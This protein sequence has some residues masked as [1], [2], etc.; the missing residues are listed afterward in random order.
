[1]K[2]LIKSLHSDF[3]GYLKDESRTVGHAET[4]SFPKS[5]DEICSILAEL[6]KTKTKITLQ[7]ARTGLAAGA[8]PFGGHV[9]NLGKMNRVLGLRH[10]N[11]LFYVSVQPGVILS[12]L[13]KDIEEKRFRMDGW[14]AESV[15]AAKKFADS[16]EHFFPTDP[17]ESSAC[18]GGIAACNA[19]GARSYLYKS[20]R[21]HISALRLA[22]WDGSMLSLQRGRTFARGR[23]LTIEK[24]DGTQLYVKLPGLT[25]PDA[26]NAS[27]Y[28]VRDDMDAID[29]I[30]G[31]DG[32]LGAITEIE[33]ELLPLPSVIWGVSTFFKS[34]MDAVSFVRKVRGELTNIAAIEYFDGGAIN[35]L[36]GQKASCSAFAQLPDIA[37]EADCCVYIEIHCDCEETALERL[38]GIGGRAAASG[39]DERDTWVARNSRD[40]ESLQFFRH[41]VPES[42]NMF[43]DERKKKD[44]IITK[45]GADM[46]VQRHLLPE[47]VGV[48]REGLAE[49]GLDSAVWGHIGDSHLHV[50][51]LPRDG[52]DFKKGKELFSKWAR[53]IS[54]MGGSVSAEHGV[55]KI[56]ANFLEFMYGREHVRGMAETK[57]CFD[58]HFIFGRGNLFPAGILSEEA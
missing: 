44:P 52:E 48:Y 25:M 29:L 6:A 8:V 27:G 24:E 23:E 50:N 47:V 58:P 28:Y 17:T 54:D 33:L 1:M 31:S 38:Y 46:S 49:Y 14:S 19:S 45:L 56:K 2:D 30:I 39:G 34:E 20:A 43:I 26:K 5:E 12:Q 42:V 37:R 11:G 15:A 53:V 16:S 18:I 40:Q 36:R 22:L 35:I 41:A 4:I 10:E 57:R 51:I 21:E 13:K 9:M 55:G 3:S 7:G 32:T